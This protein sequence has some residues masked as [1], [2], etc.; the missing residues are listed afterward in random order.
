M[1]SVAKPKLL[2]VELWGLGDLAIATPFLQAASEKFA[3]TL[4][5]KPYGR[6][7]AARFWPEVKVVPF[8]APW[9]AFRRK[10][11]V[12]TWPWQELLGLLRLR[13]ERYDV[14]I[15]ARWDPRDHFLLRAF[16]VRERIGFARVGSQVLLTRALARP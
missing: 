3:V 13:G 14:G 5:A 16:K 2:V 11:R 15:T 4:L 12:L 1:S 7:L 8:V 6:D 10:Y 9:T